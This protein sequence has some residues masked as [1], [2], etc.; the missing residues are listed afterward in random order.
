MSLF[1]EESRS[2]VDGIQFHAAAARTVGVTSAENQPVGL[3]IDD[4][5][6]GVRRSAATRALNK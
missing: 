3:E 1:G 5:Q 6:T 4:E 2:P